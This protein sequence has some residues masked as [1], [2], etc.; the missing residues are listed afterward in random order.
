MDPRETPQP[1]TI[2]LETAD[3][4]RST[5]LIG[6]GVLGST[7]AD[8][9]DVL[10]ADEHVLALHRS[11]LPSAWA[12]DP[13]TL[14]RG[15]GAKTWDRLGVLLESLAERHVERAARL[16]AFGGGAATDA[17][18]LAAALYMRGIAFTACPTSLLAMVD[19]S[20]GGKTAVNLDAGK[21]LVGAFWQPDRVVAD[22]SLLTT[23][24]DPEWR[25]GLGEVLKTAVIGGEAELETLEHLTQ[26]LIERDPQASA[27][28]IASC[29]RIKARVVSADERESGLRAVLNLGHTVGHA[30]EQAAGHGELPHGVC[31]AAGI[32]VALELSRELGMLED[33]A[34]PD[35]VAELAR[36][37]GLPD[38]LADLRRAAGLEL[39]PEELL[40]AMQHDKKGRGGTPRFV[41]PRALG[42]IEHGI[43]VERSAIEVALA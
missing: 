34:L 6:A 30:V 22:T 17:T 14:P 8:D 40:A 4:R 26:A 25:S 35:R 21:N 36:R 28:I 9:T 24:D 16:V 2:E 13:I 3:G 12:R 37:L 43:E 7:A 18:G 15:E 42:R 11:A 31:V 1:T 27:E 20:V 38:S 33:M 32:A 23:L 5:V 29:V 19:A 10:V 41:V 39:A